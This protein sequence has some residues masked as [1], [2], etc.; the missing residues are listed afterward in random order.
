[1]GGPLVT[2]LAV[3]PLGMVAWGVGGAG[4]CLPRP[5]CDGV[6]CAAA[7]P[8]D[9]EPDRSGRCA[10]VPGDVLVLGACV[11]PA[12]G[13]AYCGPAARAG[14]QGCVFRTCATGELLDA[15]TG[16]CLPASSVADAARVARAG[17]VARVGGAAGAA[18]AAGDAA[19]MAASA[20]ARTGVSC[21]DG[22]APAVIDARS[23]CVPADVACPRGTRRAGVACARLASCPPGSLPVALAVDGGAASCRPVVTVG[24]RSDLR[25]V[26]IGAWSAIVLGVD[27][28]P[29]TP[30]LCR[31]LALRRGELG[32]PQGVSGSVSVR[33]ALVAPD[34]DMTR[35]HARVEARVRQDGTQDEMQNQTQNEHDT[36]A[37][38]E[39]EGAHEPAHEEEH[40]PEHQPEHQTRRSDLRPLSAD[41]SVLVE[42]ALDTLI[43]PLRSLGGEASAAV[44]DFGVTCR[45]GASL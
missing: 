38:T 11:P 14:A 1:M 17:G 3:G 18:G 29:G 37:G 34:Q 42:R 44:F 41:A 33:I 6:A 26:D 21:G 35:V 13:D 9:A 2:R 8:R 28:G 20:E 30:D 10:C 45:L 31:P 15:V 36:Q 19:G 22:G 40:E 5:P 23:V 43:E 39:P 32:L 7:C 4:G 12:V 24:A 25:R 27:G 16:Q